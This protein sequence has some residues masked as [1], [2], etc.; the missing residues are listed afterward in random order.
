MEEDLRVCNL[1]NKIKDIT[2]FYLKAH[3]VKGK[4]YVNYDAVCKECRLKQ[5][6]LKRMG[7]LPPKEKSKKKGKSDMNK[8]TNCTLTISDV[9][10]VS[11]KIKY[12]DPYDFVY[13]NLKRYGNCIVNVNRRIDYD[14]LETKLG[15]KVRRNLSG[16][17][18]LLEAY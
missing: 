9:N 15:K 1:C 10:Y 5:L 16:N 18:Y 12:E 13:S 7:L 14:E 4:Y 2:D 6:K 11:P 3:R 8:I 17:C